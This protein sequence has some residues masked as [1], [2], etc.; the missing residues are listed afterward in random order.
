MDPQKL[1]E[2]FTYIYVKSTYV[3]VNNAYLAS[4]AQLPFFTITEILSI[5][6]LYTFNED[7]LIKLKHII[8]DKHTIKDA[9]N[10]LTY[11]NI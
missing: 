8:N 2:W 7:Q 5:L 10:M 11:K 9:L 3:Q 4:L 1:C 6:K